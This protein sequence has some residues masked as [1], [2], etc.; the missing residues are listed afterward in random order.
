MEQSLEQLV[1]EFIPS[2]HPVISPARLI[3]AT[4][5]ATVP[6]IELAVKVLVPGIFH[7]QEFPGLLNEKLGVGSRETSNCRLVTLLGFCR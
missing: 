6:T 2:V 3:C 4:V 5:G 7:I 1:S